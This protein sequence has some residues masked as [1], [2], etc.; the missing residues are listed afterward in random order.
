LYY[1]RMRNFLQWQVEPDLWKV[2]AQG[3]L[4]ADRV[5]IERDGC[6]VIGGVLEYSKRSLGM[7]FS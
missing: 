1:S 6:C 5:P 7:R 4:L 3:D 2:G